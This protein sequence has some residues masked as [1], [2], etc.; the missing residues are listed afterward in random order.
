MVRH[1]DFYF[2]LLA[3]YQQIYKKE[4]EIF[5]TQIPRQSGLG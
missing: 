1:F 4:H 2:S 5:I 3:V